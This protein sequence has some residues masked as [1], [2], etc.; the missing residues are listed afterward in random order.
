VDGAEA[1]VPGTHRWVPTGMQVRYRAMARGTMRATATLELPE[2]LA[3]KQTVA[4]DIPVFDKGGTEVFSAT[5][6]IYVTA[7]R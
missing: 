4:V 3:D 6:D 7:K 5:I 2:P 1:T